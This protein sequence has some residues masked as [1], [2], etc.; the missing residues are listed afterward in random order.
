MQTRFLIIIASTLFY[1]T[2][3]SPPENT[4]SNTKSINYQTVKKL[5]LNHGKRWHVNAATNIGIHNMNLLIKHAIRSHSLNFCPV[6]KSSLEY[7]ISEIIMNCDLKGQVHH[8]LH[9][10][11]FSLN[12]IVKQVKCTN[13]KNLEEEYQL[14]SNELNEYHNYFQ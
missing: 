7:E 12:R 3:S 10:Y 9:L 2:C 8:Q 1:S 6:L 4:K 11:L 13:A 14:I 5:Q